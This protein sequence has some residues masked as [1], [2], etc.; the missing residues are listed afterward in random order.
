PIAQAIRP[1]SSYTFVGNALLKTA[2]DKPYSYNLRYRQAAA[3]TF[4]AITTG[5]N[6]PKR[7]QPLGQLDPTGLAPGDYIVQLELVAPG[8]DPVTV[9]RP[10]TI[11][12]QSSGA[13]T[14]S[15]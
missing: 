14:P 1:G 9:Q 10:F 15:T 2:D 3:A 5:A 8:Q 6:G 13:V 12:A 7:A 4:T 11:A